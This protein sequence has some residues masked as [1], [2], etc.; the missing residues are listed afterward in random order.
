[1]EETNTIAS[2]TTT[3]TAAAAAAAAAGVG[4]EV[5]NNAKP[6]EVY[7]LD[8]KLLKVFKSG[9][10]ASQALG[11]SQVRLGAISIYLLPILSFLSIYPI[12]LSYPI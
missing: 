9:T 6:V 7:S 1:M 10:A 11:L 12:Y 4:G 2:T 3:T 5:R 8:G